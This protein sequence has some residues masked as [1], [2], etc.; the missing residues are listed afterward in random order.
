[1]KSITHTIVL[2]DIRITEEDLIKVSR[3][4]YT[5][6]ED[7]CKEVERVAYEYIK[8]KITLSENKEQAKKT[9]SR[10]QNLIK[11]IVK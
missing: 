3:N 11:S 6:A 10:L 1:M 7:L 4:N 8:E 5:F 9:A 2:P